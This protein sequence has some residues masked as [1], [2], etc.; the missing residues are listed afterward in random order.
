MKII[1]EINELYELQNLNPVK[2]LRQCI[3]PHAC[4]WMVK[5]HA[6]GCIHCQKLNTK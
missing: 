2:K 3:Q 4:G 6:C 1:I 5:T